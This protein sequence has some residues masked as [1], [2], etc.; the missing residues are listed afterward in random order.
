MSAYCTCWC[1]LLYCEHFKLG[2]HF[3]ITTI[4]PWF[5]GYTG[6][7]KSISHQPFHMFDRCKRMS[8]IP[9]RGCYMCS[10]EAV[11]QE[12]VPPL[13]LFPEAKDLPP[14][15]DYR[16]SLITV[17]SCT[18]HNLSKSGDD[19]YL[20]FLLVS[21]WGVNSAG[22]GQWA[23]KLRRSMDRRP[24][25]RN[26]FRNPRSINIRGV[27]TGIYDIDFER[28]NNELDRISRALYYHHFHQHWF[29]LVDVVVPAALEVGS[30]EAKH[31][32]RVVRETAALAIRF[33]EKEPLFGANPE[34]FQYQ[35]KL[36]E[37]APGFIFRLIFYRGIDIVTFSELT[38]KNYHTASH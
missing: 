24:A 20:L 3:I 33:L 11:S 2:Y 36:R 21:N 14:G 10:S 15:L 12:H 34:I 37:D 25:K 13:C 23:T 26:I 4:R 7:S 31:N 17:P 1:D 32:N 5:G 30:A 27:T 16:K 18:E 28:I 19:E 22:L 38:D 9:A 35:Y 8:P 6:I 29:H